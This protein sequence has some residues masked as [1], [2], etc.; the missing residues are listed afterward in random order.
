MNFSRDRKILS[1]RRRIV[2]STE[3]FFHTLANKARERILKTDLYIHEILNF[4]R[5]A[6]TCFLFFQKKKNQ[7]TFFNLFPI[8]RC[9]KLEKTIKFVSNDYLTGLSLDFCRS[10]HNWK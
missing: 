7:Y 2:S 5:N 9:F 3:I 8:S 6:E 10:S 1:Y 4:D